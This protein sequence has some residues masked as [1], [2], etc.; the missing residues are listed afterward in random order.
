MKLPCVTPCRPVPAWTRRARAAVQAAERNMANAE[1]GYGHAW[2]SRPWQSHW[3]IWLR[4]RSTA[5]SCPL[6]PRRPSCP[7]AIS[8]PAGRWTMLRCRHLAC[9]CQGGAGSGQRGIAGH[10]P[11]WL[12]G[13]P[14]R[15][16]RVVKGRWSSSCQPRHSQPVLAWS[17]S[18]A[19]ATTWRCSF[20]SG[21]AVG[22]VSLSAL[23]TSL[24]SRHGVRQGL[25]LPWWPAHRWHRRRSGVRATVSADGK[26]LSAYNLR[27]AAE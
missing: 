14:S 7:A 4:W 2:A 9:A 19:C 26:P 27:Q 10:V 24:P 12:E 18:M 25:V 17:L 20:N 16:H 13:R 8:R 11:P 3:R 21:A 1:P 23:W 15:L 5:L 6:E 22:D